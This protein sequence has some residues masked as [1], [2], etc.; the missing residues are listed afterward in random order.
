[1]PD[2]NQALDQ[3][4]NAALTAKQ[5]RNQQIQQAQQ[6]Q[7]QQK[8]FDRL[9]DND[10]RQEE[11]RKQQT[12]Q[13]KISDFFAFTKELDPNQI[14]T[15]EAP[16]AVKNSQYGG[17]WDEYQAGK[18]AEGVR[19]KSLR[20]LNMLGA[21]A[22]VLYKQERMSDTDKAESELWMA[23]EQ[24]EI[25]AGGSSGTYSGKL[26][27]LINAKRNIPEPTVKSK[28]FIQN[29]LNS[30]VPILGLSIEELQADPTFSMMSSKFVDEHKDSKKSEA[31]L[32]RLFAVEVEKLK[33][34]PEPP[35]KNKSDLPAF[36]QPGGKKK[37]KKMLKDLFTPHEYYQ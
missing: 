28:K 36:W 34:P 37:A 6:N 17:M 35:P 30:A 27:D 29:A 9:L 11:Y 5:Q 19:M 7:F 10:R 8:Q 22:D 32:A 16:D 33:P 12:E 23:Q 4:L 24:A 3:L 20:D 31:E 21:Q 1:M 26:Q 14:A 25:M 15:I 13:R 2:F 18:A